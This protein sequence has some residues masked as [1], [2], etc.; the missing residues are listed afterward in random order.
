MQSNNVGGSGAQPDSLLVLR[1]CWIAS[2]DVRCFDSCCVCFID[3]VRFIVDCGFWILDGEAR[4]G[5]SG[6]DES[7]ITQVFV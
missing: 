1:E 6:S 5:A 2:Y 4:R 7:T 3:W